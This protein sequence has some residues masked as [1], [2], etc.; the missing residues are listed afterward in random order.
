MQYKI[1]TKK[2]YP[3]VKIYSESHLS[4]SKSQTNFKY[5]SVFDFLYKDQEVRVVNK[6]SPLSNSLHFIYYYQIS[7]FFNQNHILYLMKYL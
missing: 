4:S 3:P 7:V 6:S 5:Y 2:H 1:N